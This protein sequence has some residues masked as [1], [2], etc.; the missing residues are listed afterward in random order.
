MKRFSDLRTGKVLWNYEI[1]CFIWIISETECINILRKPQ[2]YSSEE[3]Q[4]RE[5]MLDNDW[6]NYFTD[7]SEDDVY[8]INE[9][10]SHMVKLLFGEAFR[11]T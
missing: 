8:D 7:W 3:I 5:P 11:G 2:N 10:R 4:F 6:E 1:D 9:V